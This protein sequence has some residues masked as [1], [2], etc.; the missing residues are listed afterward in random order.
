MPNISIHPIN[1]FSDNYIWMLLNEESNVACVVDPGDA[2][3]VLA[4]LSERNC[5]LDSIL[6][7]HHHFDHTGGVE[8]LKEETGCKVYGPRSNIP[9]IDIPLHE[10]N[11][12]RI[13]G[14]EFH[15]IEIPGHT[16]DHIAYYCSIN[17]P[18]LFCGDTLFAGGCGRVFEGTHSMMHQSLSKLAM[19]PGETLVDCAHEYT[20]ANLEFAKTVE[21]NND[22]LTKRHRKVLIQRANDQITLPSTIELEKNTNPFLR[23]EEKE[24]LADMQNRLDLTSVDPIDIFSK[25]RSMKDNFA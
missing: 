5:S 22:E 20:H 21:P 16:L 11:M 4:E 25:I 18:L 3:P 12:V 8:A 13:L 7:T 2:D 17:T 9:E 23:C 15:V 19:L 24:L 6:V 1:A 10:S 14:L